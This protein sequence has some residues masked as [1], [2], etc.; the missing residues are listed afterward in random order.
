MLSMHISDTVN[1]LVKQL[2]ID[3]GG[4]EKALHFSFDLQLSCYDYVNEGGPTY[5][6]DRKSLHLLYYLAP[7]RS[8]VSVFS[9]T[10][11]NPFS[12]V[13]GITEWSH[14]ITHDSEWRNIRA[15]VD[16]Y[17]SMA[18]SVNDHLVKDGRTTVAPRTMTE[19]NFT[20]RN[21]FQWIPATVS[22]DPTCDRRYRKIITLG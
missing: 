12:S 8:Y 18:Q 22:L 13:N 7:K 4:N 19:H 6:S 14:E 21:M 20:I 11:N 17:F 16:T 5:N 1:A 2:L 3:A 9:A 15:F 10:L